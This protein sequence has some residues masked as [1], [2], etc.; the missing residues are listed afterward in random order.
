[1]L[2]QKDPP[3]MRQVKDP[4]GLGGQRNLYWYEIPTTLTL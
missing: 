3:R 4:R 2:A 1:M